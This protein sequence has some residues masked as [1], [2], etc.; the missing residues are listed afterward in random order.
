MVSSSIFISATVSTTQGLYF[1]DFNVLGNAHM[2][3]KKIQR[4][5]ESTHFEWMVYVS[6][7]KSGTHLEYLSSICDLTTCPDSARREKALPPIT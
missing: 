4:S 3:M 1:C 2:N 6:I 5:I 7:Q